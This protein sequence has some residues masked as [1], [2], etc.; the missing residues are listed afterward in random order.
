M[1]R[2]EPTVFFNQRPLKNDLV[3]GMQASIEFAQSI[4]IPSQS[5]SLPGDK[6]PRLVA[7]RNTL[8]MFRPIGT[9]IDFKEGIIMK[10]LLENNPLYSV[11]LHDFMARPTM[12]GKVE[13][14]GQA[15]F[16][17]P[18]QYDRLIETQAEIDLIAHDPEASHFKTLLSTHNTLNVK[19]ANERWASDFYLPGHSTSL[20]GKKIVFHSDAV[21]ESRV[22]YGGSTVRLRRGETLVFFNR[23]GV[24]GERIDLEFQTID[25]APDL[26]SCIIPWQHVKPG[27]TLRFDAA[28]ISGSYN[29]INIG[30]PSELLLNTIDIG[31]LTPNNDVFSSRFSAELQR[32]YFQQTP[33]SRLV[34]NQY[35]P[36][37]WKEIKLPSGEVISGASTDKGDVHNGDLRQYTGKELISLGINNASYGIHSSPGSGED[38]LNKHFAAAQFTAHTSVGNYSNGRVVH[39]LSG[40]GSIVTLVD[41]VGNEFSHEL[42]HNY[43]IGHYPEKFTGSVHRSSEAINSSWGW[44]SNKHYFIPNFEKSCFN[45]PTCYEGTCQAPFHGHSFGTDT[46]AGGFPMCTPTNGYTLCTPHTHHHIQQFMESKAIF[47]KTSSTGYLKW[48]ETSKKLEEWGEFHSAAADEFDLSSMTR[49]L[50]D[51]RLVEI[52]LYDNHHA[53]DVFIPAAA[54]ANKSKGIHVVHYASWGATLRINGTSVPLVRG[55]VLNYESNGSTWVEVKDFSF[56][57]VRKP[58]QQGI[59]VTTLL[60]Y[61]DPRAGYN[62]YIFPA[63]HCAYGNSYSADRDVEINAAKCY[64]EVRNANNQTLKFVLRSSRVQATTPNR[65]HVNVPSSFSPT[66]AA[67]YRDGGSVWSRNLNPPNGNTRVTITGRQ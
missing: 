66:K 35:E 13:G 28:N 51:Y 29:S 46:M 36:V 27:I 37:Y 31:M 57:V 12:A 4:I 63:L 38:G 48:N 47:D 14:F 59:P 39:G 50:N 44:D 18:G 7:L 53:H 54:A 60:G 17:E 22:H 40:G 41:C 26:R 9:A 11:K 58:A 65:F 49:L 21:F 24:W 62:N 43:G 67:L 6:K 56:N 1:E 64:L 16:I 3:N 52:P 61:Y 15:D 55:T 23:Q 25:Y 30:A 10:V 19:L 33:I 5:T 34:V 32:Q 20:K 8:V 45:L 2:V 42:G